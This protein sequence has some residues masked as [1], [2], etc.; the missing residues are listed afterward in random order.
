MFARMVEVVAKPG[1]R[2]EV[3]SIGLNELMPLIKKQRGFIDL[4]VM[5]DDT[6]ADHGT[7]LSLWASREE[8]ERFWMSAEFTAAMNRVTPLMEHM[9]FRTFEVETLASTAAALGCFSF[10]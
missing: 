2:A 5:T 9:I 7:T 4:I 3:I 1:K 10:S 6:R 8:S